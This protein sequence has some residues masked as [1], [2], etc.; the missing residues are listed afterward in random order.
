MVVLRPV[1]EFGHAPPPQTPYSIITNIPGWDLLHSIREGDM[2]SLARLVHIYPRFSPTHF[3]ARLGQEVAKK[4][5]REGMGCMVYL[6]PIMWKYTAGHVT[7]EQRGVHGIK[8]EDVTFKVIDV[9]GHRV[10]AVLFEPQH[11]KALMLSWGTPGIGIS[12][13]G[14]ECLLKQLHTMMEVPCDASDPPE[15]T[16]TPEGPAHQALRQRIITFLHRAAIDPEKVQCKTKDVFL[17]PSGMGAFFHTK[18]LIQGY[19]PGTNVELGIV[20]HNTHELLQEESLDGWKHIGKVDKNA[21]DSMEAWLEEEAKEGRKV[22]F[23]IVEFPGNPTLETLDLHRLKQLSQ[24]YGFVLIV[25]D[26]IAGF[27]NVDVLAYSDIQLTSLTKSFSGKSNVLGGSIVLNPLS[28]H[29]SGL[30]PRF[31]RAHHNELFVADA[32]VLLANS[33]DFLARTCRLNHNAEVMANFL[34]KTIGEHDSPITRVHYPSLL[35][36]KPEYD[37]FK[38]PSMPELPEPGYGCL[39]TVDFESMGIAKAF[40]DRC[41]F[42]PS[43]HLGGHVTIMLPYNMFR[44]GKEPAERAKLRE[45]GVKE[46]SVRISAGLEDVRDLIDTLKDALVA[47]TRAKQNSRDDKNGTE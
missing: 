27:G 22:S 25:D 10:Y 45:L 15:P 13:R 40:Y 18:N 23:A 11:E 6:N 7:R 2:S 4:I 14:A 41:G 5:G 37:V 1:S 24:K 12:I 30:F 32:E 44:L 20:F 19:R 28:P 21:I 36:S 38:R 17:Y 9:A 31:A 16:W 29:Y 42:Y 35:S 46:E 39:L 8:A 34:H 26:T 43:P 33:E 3:A 47:A